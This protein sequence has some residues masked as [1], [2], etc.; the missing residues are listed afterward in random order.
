MLDG[1]I[2]MMNNE[3]VEKSDESS[4]IWMLR[5]VVPTVNNFLIKSYSFKNFNYGCII[6]M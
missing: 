4:S 3:P 1:P 6:R 2:H 5:R